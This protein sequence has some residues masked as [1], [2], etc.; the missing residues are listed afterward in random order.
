MQVKPPWGCWFGLLANWLL[1]VILK[2]IASRIS[3]AAGRPESGI[4]A[5]RG[6]SS[7]LAGVGVKLLPLRAGSGDTRPVAERGGGGGTLA[8]AG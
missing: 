1:L 2:T 3:L 4:G 5:D 8:L 6:R 7:A